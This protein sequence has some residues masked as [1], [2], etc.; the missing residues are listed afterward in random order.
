MSI[1]GH[2]RLSVSL[3]SKII[4]EFPV[5]LNSSNITSSIREPVSMSA[6]D[7]IVNEPPSST[8]RAAPKNRLGRCNALASTPPVK[9]LPDDGTTVL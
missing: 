3:R 2:V 5:P 7:I 4:S 8:F 6:V 9:T 1:D